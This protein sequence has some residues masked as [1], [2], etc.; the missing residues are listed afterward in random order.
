M[1][2]DQ[3]QRSGDGPHEQRK[4]LTGRREKDA[5]KMAMGLRWHLR[6]HLQ[7]LTTHSQNC[8]RKCMHNCIHDRIKKGTNPNENGHCAKEKQRTASKAKVGRKERCPILLRTHTRLHSIFF[9]TALTIARA[10]AAVRREQSA[11]NREK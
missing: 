6:W 10:K 11:P 3:C 5:N 4:I 1:K 8:L 9:L 2:L 7:L